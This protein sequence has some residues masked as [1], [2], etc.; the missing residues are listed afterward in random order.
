MAPIIDPRRGDFEDDASSTRQRSLLAIAGSLL[1]EISL[2]KLILAWLLLVILPG[3]LLGLAPLLGSAWL[4]AFSRRITE[5]F[6][7][8]LP[9]LLFMVVIAT[10]WFG[11]RPLFRAVEQGFWSLNSLVV[12]PAYILCREGL[13]HVAESLLRGME[14]EGRSRLR[15]ISSACAGFLLCAMAAWAA[16][17]IWPWSRWIGDFTSIAAPDL[18]A[19]TTIA[20][21]M[22]ILSGYFAIAALVWGLADATMDQ[23]R[24]LAAF[25]EKPAGAR[26]WRVAHLSDLHIIAERYGF[27]IESGRSGPR[28]NVRLMPLLQKLDALHAEKPLDVILL[29][30]DVTDSGRASEWAEFLAALE[31][32]PALAARLLVLPGNHDINVV[33]RANPAR[34]DLPTS[35][36]PRLREMRSL[37]AIAA[38]QG[39][40]VRVADLRKKSLGRTLNEVLASWRAVISTFADRGG[41]RRSMRLSQLWAEVFPM[42]LPPDREDGLGVIILNSTGETHFSFTNALGF[43]SR[44]DN[45]TIAIAVRTFPQARWIVA[46]HHHLVEY[47]TRVHAFSERIGT[48]LINGSW[49]VRQLQRL[50]R[51]AVVMHGHRHIDWI[52]HCGDLRIISAPSPVMEATDDQPRSFLIH[53]LAAG[54][55]GALCLLAPERV[56]LPGIAD[57]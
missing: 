44:E 11:G 45:Q 21:T 38:I 16:V 26:I 52:G 40:R 12:Q 53:N 55:D 24:T 7:G 20:N 47:P 32:F 10:G 33:D 37:S 18:L 43:I 27:R 1:A 41:L 46:L 56:T 50:G 2:S 19:V 51:R 57:T 23:P 3:M 8:L 6:A 34:L 31:G 4:T 28:G 49:F 30:G 42:I 15:A 25:D 13:Q 5:S 14:E 17:L 48:A 36:G 35:P 54:P 22:V 9:L 39:E 29:T